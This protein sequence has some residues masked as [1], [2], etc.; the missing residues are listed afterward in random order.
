MMG[1]GFWSDGINCAQSMV[2]PPL[3]LLLQGEMAT[4][5]HRINDFNSGPAPEG[6]SVILLCEDHAGTYLLP[7]NCEWKEGPGA[8]AKAKIL[9]K[10]RSWAGAREPQGDVIGSSRVTLLWYVTPSG[11]DNENK[12]RG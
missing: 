8:T 9:L 10:Q 4:R 3:P 5:E 11:G 1:S 2:I 7:Y 12:P 6:K